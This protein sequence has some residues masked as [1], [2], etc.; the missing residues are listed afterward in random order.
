MLIEEALVLV[1][2]ADVLALLL[3]CRGVGGSARLLGGSL[4][5]E[6]ALEGLVGRRRQCE[7]PLARLLDLCDAVMARE[8]GERVNGFLSGAAEVGKDLS[9][10]ACAVR[11]YL[12]H[13]G[14]Q[15]R[16]LASV[17]QRASSPH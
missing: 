10:E 9:R 12:V 3:E 11:S 6:D 1:D 5:R 7:H 2:G 8:V 17:F 16:R 4:C 15:V 13:L 14:E